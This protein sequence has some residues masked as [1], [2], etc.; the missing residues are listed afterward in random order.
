MIDVKGK[1]S[2]LSSSRVALFAG[3][4]GSLA[5]SALSGLDALRVLRQFQR[6]DEQ[7]RRQFLFRNRVLN[8]I[9]SEVYLSGTYVRDYLL[10]P[11]PARATAFGASLG[12]VRNQMETELTSYASQ[13]EPEESKHY[14]ALRMELAQYWEVLEPTLKW[15][16]PK[17][18]THGYAF[19]RDEVFPRRTAMLEVAGQIA[20][21]NE[22]QL[23]AG[24]EPASALLTQ[25]QTRRARTRFQALP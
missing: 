7:I 9:R 20:D 19:L 6:Q 1:T 8:N 4:G 23:N 21:I 11:N 3:F 18:Q 16:A 15:N 25:F 24:N 17:R 12:N 5:I 14:G 22:Q 10:D 13:L 2:T